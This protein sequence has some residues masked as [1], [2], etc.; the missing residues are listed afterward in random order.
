MSEASSCRRARR[1]DGSIYE[2]KDGRHRAVI[3]VPDAFKVRCAAATG[4]PD[5]SSC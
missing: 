5:A 4:D 2:T 3:S 1:G